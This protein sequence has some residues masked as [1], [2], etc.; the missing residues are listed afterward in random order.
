[1]LAVD[2]Y[3]GPQTGEDKKSYTI[4]LVLE[5]EHQTL[6]DTQIEKLVTKVM[7]TLSINLGAQIRG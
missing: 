2:V 4:G 1:V 6:T 5:D 3:K 7:Q